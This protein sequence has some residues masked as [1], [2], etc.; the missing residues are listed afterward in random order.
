LQIADVQSQIIRQPIEII[1]SS[2]QRTPESSD[3]NCFWIP[4]F[5]GMTVLEEP[6]NPKSEMEVS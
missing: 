3:V 6:I 2:L 1:T 5:A 4:A